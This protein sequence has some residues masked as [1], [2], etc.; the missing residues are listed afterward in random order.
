MKIAMISSESLPFSK[1]GGL[2]DVLFS[3][4]KAL[5]QIGHDVRIF[6]PCIKS[7]LTPAI[8]PL[9]T[10]KNDQGYELTLFHAQPEKS[11]PNL[12]FYLFHEETLITR[13]G[14]Y[15]YEHQTY[16]DNCERFAL[17][18]RFVLDAIK[19][20]NWEPHIIHCH[21]W[22]TGLIASYLKCPPYNAFFKTT[23]SVFSIHNLGYQGLFPARCAHNTHLPPSYIPLDTNDPTQINLMGAALQFADKITTV[24]PT[25]AK[26]ILTEEYS[27]GL[28]SPL[29]KREADLAGILNGIDIDKWNPGKDPALVA[30]YSSENLQGKALC[31]KA[32]VEEL[33]FRDKDRPLIAMISRLAVQKGIETLFNKD[34]GAI[35]PICEKLYA[36]IVIIGTGEPWCEEL[37]ETLTQR[38]PNFKGI[39]AFSEELSHRVEAGSDFFLM[40]SLYEP[41][42][43]N[44]MYSSHYGTLPIVRATGGLADTVIPYTGNEEEATGYHFY[45]LT[46]S[47]LFN[48]ID[49]AL[50]VMKER[51]QQHQ[52]M[53][54]NGMQKEFSWKHSALAYIKLYETL[55]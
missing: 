50:K 4:S 10:I 29:K 41:C 36:N 44:Q 21:D 13:E 45:D 25:Y 26:E 22:P 6:I 18:S 27:Q 28:S 33:G 30:N 48:T 17:F 40:P 35:Y 3:L 34:D 55:L 37:L 54:I 2:G 11:L 38:Y 5:A 24:S 43:L 12:Q 47:A 32:L 19:Q 8:Q 52:K 31:K 20:L 1:T 15:S 7:N 46:P 16:Q 14:V 49:W 51:P 39:K 42:G 23:K 9:F 53:I